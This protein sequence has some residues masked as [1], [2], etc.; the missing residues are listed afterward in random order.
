MRSPSGSRLN[1]RRVSR[2]TQSFPVVTMAVCAVLF[3]AVGCSRGQGAGPIPIATPS[4]QAG[5]AGIPLYSVEARSL[6]IDAMPE[7][8][9][10][11][12]PFQLAFTNNETFKTTDNLVVLELPVGKTA[13]DVVDDAKRRGAKALADWT[14]AGDSTPQL[15]IGGTAV[16]T[17][18]LARGNYVATSWGTGKAGGGSGPPHVALGMIVP[19]TATGV[20][21][22][23]APTGPI[24]SVSVK[25]F[26][27]QG[28]PA[29]VQ[30]NRPF[31]VTFINDEAFPILHEFVVLKLPAGKTAQDVV[32]DARKKGPGA[33][34]DW[35]HVGDSGAP[36]PAGAS[37][38][39]RMDL[40]PGHY[41]A[42]C[43]QT[44]KV[45]GGTGPPHLVLG[46]IAPFTVT[47]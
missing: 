44:G 46:M 4:V 45:G 25:N 13:Q 31:E 18:T 42:T 34:D 2:F 16:L 9:T 28:V 7:T 35:N 5:A 24:Y 41:V 11:G 39:V 21:P 17:L 27:F 1:A 10:A 33:E 23:A 26:T 47:G 15:P 8:V 14:R 29:T 30:A 19:F 43:W 3:I 20:V 32:D 40:K 12:K 36:L 6:H 22:S 37:A 38:V